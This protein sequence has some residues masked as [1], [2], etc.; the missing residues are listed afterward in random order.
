MVLVSTVRIPH[1][2]LPQLPIQSM[3]CGSCSAP[4]TIEPP[5]FTAPDDVPGVL[6]DEEHA[7]ATSAT[8]AKSKARARP[9]VRRIRHNLLGGISSLPSKYP[10]RFDMQLAQQSGRYHPEWLR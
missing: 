7:A 3:Q 2:T 8:V 1:A 9:R 5:C 10:S 6:L 4:S